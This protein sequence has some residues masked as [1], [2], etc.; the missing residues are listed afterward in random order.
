MAILY[1]IRISNTTRHPFHV[2]KHG[3]CQSIEVRVKKRKQQSQPYKKTFT[4]VMQLI[5][6]VFLVAALQLELLIN[7]LGN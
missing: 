2:C 7:I 3:K 6:R 4:K 5:R 1:P